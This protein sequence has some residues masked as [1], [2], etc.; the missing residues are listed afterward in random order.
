MKKFIKLLILGVVT[1][2]LTT[3][4]FKRDSLEGIKIYTTVYPIEYLTETLYGNNSTVLSIY[5]NGVNVKE[6]KL[7]KKQIN[8]YSKAGLFIYNG[9]SNEKNIAKDF[10]NANHKIKIIDVSYGLKYENGVEELWLSPNNYLMLATTIKNNL[11]DFIKSKYIIE[12]IE[13]NYKPLQEEV[14][15]MD[16]ELRVIASSAKDKNQ[17]TI[18]VSN[19]VFKYLNNYGYNIICL[20]DK[21][22]ISENNLNTIKSNYKNKKYKYIMMANTDEKT[23]L[24]NDLVKNYGAKIITINTMTNLT[25]ED[26]ENNLNYITFMKEYIENIRTITLGK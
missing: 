15:R 10:I 6:Y 25:T 23:D 19:K 9:L 4:C 13:N 26:R 2:G 18:V 1:I 24:I 5:P 22:A 8:K 12:E 21:E 3:A 17:E 14:S 20:E 7:T 16:A 11:E